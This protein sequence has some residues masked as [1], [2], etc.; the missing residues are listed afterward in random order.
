MLF[1][2][3]SPS[4]EKIWM[5]KEKSHKASPF[6]DSVSMCEMPTVYAV[7][8]QSRPRCTHLGLWT[9]NAAP[10]LP[11]GSHMDCKCGGHCTPA[12]GEGKRNTVNSAF[13]CNKTESPREYI[14]KVKLN[15]PQKTPHI[16]FYRNEKIHCVI[17]MVLELAILG[18]WLECFAFRS[19]AIQKPVC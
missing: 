7:M 5:K 10:R 9:M 6:I 15:C 18:N 12:R 3:L 17:Q 16:S 19:M 1:S 4:A 11:A 2:A 8:E 13:S 14:P